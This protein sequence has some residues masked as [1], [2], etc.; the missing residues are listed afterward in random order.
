MI[1]LMPIKF[2]E[3]P[4]RTWRRRV[5]TCTVCTCIRNTS[6]D[7]E[8]TPAEPVKRRGSWKHLHGRGEDL[9]EVPQPSFD[10]E[11]PPRTWRRLNST[12][13]N[14]RFTR[15]HLHGRGEDIAI[16]ER[17]R[18]QRETPPRTWRRPQ[19]NEYRRGRHGNTS[20][21]V[22]K[23]RQYRLF[24]GKPEKHLHGRGEDGLPTGIAQNGQETP[25]RTWRRPFDSRLPRG[26][27]RKH[28][29]GRGE[30]RP[31][32]V[33]STPGLGNTSTD[34]EKTVEWLYLK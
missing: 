7:V 17:C 6:T 18:L 24:L 11:T 28:L 1:C 33:Y 12:S 13:F 9:V 19:C 32:P 26:V 2:S 4:P 20:T 22:E 3:T 34:V 8:K 29:H 31:M 25:P 23:T 21:D 14:A 27:D 5:A 15:K 10:P 30:D 16:L